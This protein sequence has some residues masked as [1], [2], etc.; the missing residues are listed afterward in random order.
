MAELL[1][2]FGVDAFS[3][4]IVEPEDAGQGRACGCICPGC[5]SPLL[6]R[7]PKDERR[8]HFSHDSRHPDAK[9]LE[10]CPFNSALAVAIMARNLV[11]EL[12]GKVIELPDYD[13]TVNF[14]CCERDGYAEVAQKS[15][16]LI[17]S[18]SSH[19]Q[20]ADVKMDFCVFIK[21]HP[22]NIFL[23]YKDRP[24]PKFS[25]DFCLES[26]AAVISINCESFDRSLL[27]KNKSLRFSELVLKFLLKDGQRRWLAHPRESRAVENVKRNHDC[28]PIKEQF[29]QEWSNDPL[30][31][32]ALDAF[33]PTLAAPIEFQPINY[34]CVLCK[35]VWLQDKPGDPCCPKGHGRIYCISV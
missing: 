11:S 20:L 2:P 29:E 10:K 26:N 7:H 24:E 12:N 23:H 13:V 18:A 17:E 3:G 21:G 1:I 22:L 19:A 32:A 25:R 15:E 8:I 9:A 28:N 14:T 31:S 4:L 5:G 33:F 6:S 16:V 35:T 27:K 34:H 30:D